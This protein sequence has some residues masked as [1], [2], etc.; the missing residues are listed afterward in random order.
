M[1]SGN[2]VPPPPALPAKAMAEATSAFAAIQ[3]SARALRPFRQGQ[4]CQVLISAGGGHA[5]QSQT[6][7][8]SWGEVVN[9]QHPASFHQ[10]QAGGRSCG[11]TPGVFS[12]ATGCSYHL[13]GGWH[14]LLE[15]LKCTC[16]AARCSQG[17][18]KCCCRLVPRQRDQARCCCSACAEGSPRSQQEQHV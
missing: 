18:C 5:L 9:W 16:K 1:T 3:G 10:P 8:L 4:T 14:A 15:M 6:P 2:W 7:V 11:T 12:E 17:G 13:G